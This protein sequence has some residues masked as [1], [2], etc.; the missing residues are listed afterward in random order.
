[1]VVQILE[2]LINNSV[3]WL[4]YQ[5]RLDPRFEP[6]ISLMVDINA[7]EILFQDNGPGVDP[8][9]RDQVFQP[10]YTTKPPGQG[11]G[12]GLYIAREVA[13]YNSAA[14][15]L[16]ERRAVHPDRLNTFVFSLEVEVQ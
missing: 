6:E 12:L 5:K 13:N 2:N 15:Y 14:L 10:F 3:Y 7:R 8:S 11:K 1:M 16:S 4:K 9:K